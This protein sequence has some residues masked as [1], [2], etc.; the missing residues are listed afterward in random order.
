MATTA[1]DSV[2][3]EE[4]PDDT[5]EGVVEDVEDSD[6]GP[7]GDDGQAEV[8]S[9]SYIHILL[10][11]EMSSASNDLSIENRVWERRNKTEA[12]RRVERLFQSLA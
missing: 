10:V 1:E 6:D 5:P 11:L 7:E 4:V 12:R 3:I 9:S 2:T 8:R